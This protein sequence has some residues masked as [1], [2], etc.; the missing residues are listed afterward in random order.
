MWVLLVIG[1][2]NVAGFGTGGEFT[3]KE[4]CESAFAALEAN[5]KENRSRAFIWHVCAEK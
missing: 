1:T 3:T 4:R 5:M 2:L